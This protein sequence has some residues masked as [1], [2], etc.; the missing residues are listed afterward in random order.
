MPHAATSFVG[1]EAERRALVDAIGRHR[2]VTAI[3]PGG[4]GKTRLVLRVAAEVAS[5]LPDGVVYVDLAHVNDPSMVAAAI[6]EACDVPERH[7]TSLE[8]ALTASLSRRAVLLVVDNCEHVLDGVRDCL[9]AILAGCADARVL[10]TSRARFLTP[11]EHVFAVPGMS[12]SDGVALFMTRAAAAGAQF[13]DAPRVAVL[14]RALDGMALAIELAAARCSSLGLDGL[15]AGLDLRLRFLSGGGPVADRQRSLRNAIAWS[16]DLLDDDDRALLRTV[17]VFACWFDVGAAAALARRDTVGVADGLARLAEHSLLLVDRSDPTRFRALE[18]IRQFGAEQLAA[19]DALEEARARHLRWCRL[20]LR[21]LDPGNGRATDDA[22]CAALDAM[23]DDIRAALAFAESDDVRAGATADL[24]TAFA[25]AL[26]IRGRPTEAQRRFEQA[27]AATPDPGG[28]PAL[29]RL[30]AG[31]AYSRD[32]GLEA[33]ALLQTA[34]DLAIARGDDGAAAYDLAVISMLVSRCPG[35][36]SDATARE[37]ALRPLEAARHRSD[38]AERAT[39]AIATATVYIVPEDDSAIPRLAADGL[40]AALRVDDRVLA[41]AVLDRLC[42]HRLA[43]ADL[44]GAVAAV[45][46]RER[47]LADVVID[48][49][50]GFELADLHLT[51]AE[52]GL[53]TGDLPTARRHADAVAALPFHRGDTHLALARR[54]NVDA[55]AGHL[56]D[57]AELG[58]RFR[59]HWIRAGRPVASHLASAAGAVAMVHALRGDDIAR[60]RWHSITEALHAGQGRRR[61]TDL[62][63]SHTFDGL[64]ALDA[65]DPAAALSI[66]DVDIDDDAQWRHWREGIWRPWYAALWAEASVLGC[67]DD[68]VDRIARAHRATRDNPIALAIIERAA[69]IERG[70]LGPISASATTFAGLGCVYQRD[71]SRQLAAVMSPPR[72]AATT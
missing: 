31:A 8:A 48:A 54:I 27:A 65:G 24:A 46:E 71:R 6:A 32:A 15:E 34:A 22:W 17:S 21:A 28:R 44:A 67:A 16:Y 12:T 38:G 52:V 33:M 36:M 63:W 26:Y 30:A 61:T 18:T 69:A 25:H 43:S 55:M 35:I 72:R 62:A 47:L 58:E 45:Y 42:A 9:D 19:A 4:V 1:R 41:S 49:G 29:L 7:G 60:R 5:R 68:R 50:T 70:E 20:V 66:M 3:G 14:C 37:D 13:I 59:Q 56:D 10:A 11:Y 39:A 53:A 64:L 23:V 51:G 2:M 57:V 40:A